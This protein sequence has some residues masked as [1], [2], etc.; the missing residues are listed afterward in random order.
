[1]EGL[2]VG[3][4]KYKVP[5]P[6]EVVANPTL[7]GTESDLEGLQVG[8]TKYKIPSGGNIYTHHM[9]L[10]FSIGDNRI[11]ILFNIINNNPNILTISEVLDYFTNTIPY[12]STSEVARFSV[13]GNITNNNAVYDVYMLSYNRSVQQFILGSNDTTSI[14][15]SFPSTYDLREWITQ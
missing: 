15:F 8:N 11:L 9:Y 3:N 1:M 10:Q 6:T 12:L 14:T 4:T 13:T 5:T 2:Q 7:A